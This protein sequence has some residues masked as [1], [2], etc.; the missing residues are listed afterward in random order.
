MKA[1]IFI[2]TGNRC[3]SLKR[4]L[5]SLA[6]QT[7]LPYEVIIV[8]YRSTDATHNVIES[9]RKRL[10]IRLIPQKTKGLARAA[11]LALKNTRGSLFIRT[12]DDVV[13]SRN[14]LKTIV[15]VFEHDRKIGGVTGPTVIPPSHRRNRDLFA[16]QQRMKH[17][18]PLWRL[19]GW[20]YFHI[21]LDNRSM[22]VSEWLDSGA[23][24][25][26]SNYPKAHSEKP[27]DVTNLEACNFSVRTSLLRSVGGFDT[28]YTGVGEYH[29]P[30]AACKI[31]ER[32]Y[33]LIFHPHASLEHRPSQD[34]F[35]HDRP[36]SYS[37]MTNFIRF[38]KRH[39]RLSSA[40]KFLHFTLYLI[41]LNTYYIYIGIKTKQLKQFG[42][43]PGTLVGLV[44]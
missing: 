4:T 24:T 11:N 30:D 16:L 29:E 2:P 40:R 35:F 13:M 15:S 6:R 28:R 14:W 27:H 10:T 12:D 18:G 3:E 21:L 20:I 42:A 25:L 26:G 44:S 9:F 43:I 37:R 5:Q 34:G 33:R 31:R 8:D 32:G 23:F 1:S 38:Y 17:G 39:I 36:A 41:F 22:Q 19:C 7:L